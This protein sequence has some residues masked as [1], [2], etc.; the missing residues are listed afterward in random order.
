MSEHPHPDL[1]EDRQTQRANWELWAI[2][3]IVA[4]VLV[5]SFAWRAIG[6]HRAGPDPPHAYV[7]AAGPV[8]LAPPPGGDATAHPGP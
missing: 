5:V 4:V 2:F 8:P 6:H 7:P 3:I 1:P